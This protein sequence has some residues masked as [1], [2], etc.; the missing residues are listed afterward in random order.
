MRPVSVKDR[1]AKEKQK[2]IK[3]LK[4]NKLIRH[5][6][7]LLKEKSRLVSSHAPVKQIEDVEQQLEA[8]GIDAYQKASQN[9]QNNR[10]GGDSSKILVDW[11]RTDPNLYP[12]HRDTR[13]Q[14]ILEIGSV[15]VD[16]KCSTCG[17]FSVTRIDLHSSH[18]LIQEQDVLMR[19]PKEGIFDGI[20]CSLVLNFAPP[21]LR[22]QILL[23]CTQLLHPPNPTHPPWFFFVLPAPCV[24]NSRYMDEST[25]HSILHRFGFTLRY[26]S[27]SKKIAYY[28]YAYD[29]PCS[30]NLSWKKK[31]VHD[32]PSRNNFFIP[33]LSS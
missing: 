3:G 28:L 4:G 8:I 13:P 22:A 31:T 1:V 12:K 15:C 32:G 25:L 6:H 16:N 5:Y 17:L 21:N 27:V 7:N 9:G 26:S 2:H 24:N 11:I 30:T 20:S 14:Q 23:K 33:C 19:S 18:P 29:H 10:K